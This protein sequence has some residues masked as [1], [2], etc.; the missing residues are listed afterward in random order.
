MHFS[1]I[2]LFAACV[3]VPALGFAQGKTYD[4]SSSKTVEGF[5]AVDG[6]SGRVMLYWPN[7]PGATGYL[8]TYSTK[9]NSIPSKRKTLTPNGPILSP[10]PGTGVQDRQKLP[11]TGLT[12]GVTYY[13][14]AR[15]CFN[16]TFGMWSKPATAMP[17]VN[18]YPWH[19]GTDEIMK[20]AMAWH[21]SS[22]PDWTPDTMLFVQEAN[23]VTH[24]K[25]SADLAGT[26]AQPVTRYDSEQNVFV[27]HDGEVYATMAP[28]FYGSETAPLEAHKS[29]P[30]DTIAE[31]S[32]PH[33]NAEPESAGSDTAPLESQEANKGDAV[34][35]ALRSNQEVY[36]Q[37][38]TLKA[39]IGN[40][41][42]QALGFVVAVV[43]VL[44][45]RSRRSFSGRT[46]S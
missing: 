21:Q 29:K 3:V 13:F 8:V 40:R 18:G 2:C 26:S 46:A 16:K 37:D 31:A 10:D 23:G 41:W 25:P 7:T 43:L 6:G 9:L 42:F 38:R 15:P 12:N 39:D 28:E 32:R 30:G 19:L 22:D 24:S 1:R 33:Q 14:W 11:V 27:D 36:E 45:I 17:S 35:K 5:D 4:S 20:A 44:I 34:A